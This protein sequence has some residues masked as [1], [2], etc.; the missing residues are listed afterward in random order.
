M[1]A[2]QSFVLFFF[3]F[4]LSFENLFCW[5]GIH[6]MNIWMD[7]WMD[8]YMYIEGSE[9]IRRLNIDVLGNCRDLSEDLLL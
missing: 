6:G 4:F 9:N 3:F 1:C 7:G 8:V 2:I 5:G